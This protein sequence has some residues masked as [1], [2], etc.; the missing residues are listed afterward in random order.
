MR[1]LLALTSSDLLQRMRDKSVLIFALLVPL[2]LMTV[3]NLVFGAAD[4][5]E[6]DPV[7]VVISAP[8]DDDLAQALTGVVRAL[9]GTD[10]L[11][12]T[13]VETDGSA[14]RRQVRD[15]DAALALVVPAGF[16]E[17]ARAGEPVTVDA[18]RGDE[19]GIGADIVLSVVDGV[20]DQVA[21]GAV[22]A[23]AGLAEGV[24]PADIGAL[25]EQ[26]TSG[27]P[28]YDVETGQASDEQLG[29]GAAL[30]A[31]QA[32]LF[33]LF[34]VSFGVTGLLIDR[35]S[36]TL[37]RL[38]SMPIPGWVIVAAK[39]LVSFVLGVVATGVLLTVGS[40]L[41]D[42]DFGSVPAV[43]VLVLCAA[44]AGTSVMFLVVRVARTSEQAG[45]VTSI[46]A[47]VLG[48]GGGAFFPVSATGALSG[49]L[50]LNPV[51]ALLRG[52]G[53]TS[54]GGGLTDIGPPVAIM[55]GFAVVMLLVSRLVPD[56]G[57]LS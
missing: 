29:A 10:E 32:G 34:T 27:G 5:L 30:V 17:A 28:A 15:G 35:E 3:F 7:T 38:R 6:I 48:I 41:F 25:V 40:Y 18:V 24:A 36:G 46:V 52:L 57:V 26:A 33:L 14:G 9:D 8:A 44:A 54:G 37:A 45:I 56:R 53:T 51:A 11:D 43:A 20:L 55:L 39:A 4:D 47:L 22:T 2:A 23:R 21:S 1:Q 12:V 31:G 50:D 13:V 42:A 16:G 19:A 49:V